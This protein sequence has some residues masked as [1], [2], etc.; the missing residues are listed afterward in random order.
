MWRCG[1]RLDNN[2]IPYTTKFPYQIIKSHP[3]ARL[4]VKQVH[5]RVL[6]IGVEETH[7]EIQSRFWIPTRKSFARKIK[8]NYACNQ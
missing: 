4:I 1:G 8:P 6:H 7:T 5:E 3:V 2:E